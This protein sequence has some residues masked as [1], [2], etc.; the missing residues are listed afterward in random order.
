MDTKNK[1]L[2]SLDI[3][4]TLIYSSGSIQDEEG[5]DFFNLGYDVY[6]RPYLDIF[7]QHIFKNYHV[8]I[9]STAKI[10]YIQNVINNIF[11]QEQKSQLKFVF[12]YKKCNFYDNSSRLNTLFAEGQSVERIHKYLR[13]VFRKGYDKHRVIAIDNDPIYYTSSYSNCLPIK[14]FTGNTNDKELLEIIPYL[15]FLSQQKSVRKFNHHEWKT[16]LKNIKRH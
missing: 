15:D 13:K 9:F 14:S 7:L 1:L 10:D 12:D 5:R 8:G 6:K 4:N 3:D 16:T 2:I 11:T